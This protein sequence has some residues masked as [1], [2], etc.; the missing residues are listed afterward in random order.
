MVEAVQNYITNFS[1]RMALVINNELFLTL[2][3]VSFL[4][5]FFFLGFRFFKES[6]SKSKISKFSLDFF[7]SLIFKIA[8]SSLIMFAGIA[9]SEFLI[10]I[11]SSAFIKNYY[12]S[13][14]LCFLFLQLTYALLNNILNQKLDL[15]KNAVFCIFSRITAFSIF[16]INLV[17]ISHINHFEEKF[18]SALASFC[19]FLYFSRKIILYKKKLRTF[20]S[21]PI[22]SDSTFSEKNLSLFSRN[23]FDLFI[24]SMALILFKKFMSSSLL[25]YGFFFNIIELFVIFAFYYF[26][27]QKIV[28]SVNQKINLLKNSK[29]AKAKTECLIDIS[30]ACSLFF[31]L[32]FTLI[33]I[34]YYNL[35]LYEYIITL[36]FFDIFIV[37]LFTILIYKLTQVFFVSIFD[38]NRQSNLKSQKIHTFLPII[39]M[40]TKITIIIIST[41]TILLMLKINIGP[42][43][44]V[45][46]AL[47]VTLS[48]ASQDIVKSFL[49]GLVLLSEN[50]LYVGHY[51]SVNGISGRLLQLSIRS[52]Y[53]KDSKGCVHSIPY[54]SVSTISNY[55][56]ENTI[57]KSIL[58]IDDAK[59]ELFLKFIDEII[60]K[61]RLESKYKNVIL[62]DPIIYGVKPFDLEGLKISWGVVT[63]PD[64]L[65]SV[66]LEFYKRLTLKMQSENIPIPKSTTF[67]TS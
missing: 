56:L 25:F 38:A 40:M 49:Q 23:G 29:Y 11:N 26:I 24:I 50:K 3:V 35:K 65:N 52:M 46:S 8:F 37:L 4:L 60:S 47:L 32:G 27:S 15:Q 19:V 48:L 64:P 33:I 1:P 6:L 13:I 62:S 21:Y 59:L 20:F 54:S 66:I 61:M 53:I 43:I 16:F 17:F 12:I 30:N 31:I 28:H 44:G 58:C 55:S 39:Y 18:I 36:Q 67:S 45:F 7:V 51:I 41:L 14:F 63:T 57:Q 2:G 34:R 9:L 22:T 42:I 10:P 5:I